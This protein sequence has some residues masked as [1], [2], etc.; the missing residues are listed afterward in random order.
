MKQKGHWVRRSLFKFFQ[1]SK[2][3]LIMQTS[4]SS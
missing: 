2:H 4:F 3:L 1:I